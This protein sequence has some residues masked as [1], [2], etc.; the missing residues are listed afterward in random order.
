MDN[1][2]GILKAG[3]KASAEISIQ[4]PDAP[5]IPNSALL[6]RDDKDYVIVVKEGKT[7]RTIFRIGLKNEA[8]TVVL[9]GLQAGDRI[10][11]KG[12]E[13]LTDGVEVM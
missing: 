11:I 1:T 2:E 8:S 6:H 7:V 3:M 4:S 12:A 13:Q 9:Q 10:V 5:V